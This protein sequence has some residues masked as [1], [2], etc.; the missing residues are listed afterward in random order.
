MTDPAAPK[1]QARGAERE[2]QIVTAAAELIAERGLA[3]LRVTDVADRAGLGAGHV[4]YYFRS[5]SMLLMRA[6]QQS[7]DAF[8][9]RTEAT[10]A[11]IRDPWK[12]LA[13]FIEL[14]AANGPRDPGWLL[15]FEV[16]SN[17][18]QDEEVAALHQHLDARSRELLATIIRAGCSQGVFHTDDPDQAATILAA[19]IDG[20]SIQLTL[21]KSDRTAQQVNHL[22]L[23][24]A[25]ALLDH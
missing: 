11:R 4:S 15:W 24:T 10:L 8:I 5:K 7:E 18:A 14:S 23:T 17:A 9:D 20:L 22:C 21:G 13:K 6:I 3:N 16:W 1:R 12:R 19:T 25:H 2:Q